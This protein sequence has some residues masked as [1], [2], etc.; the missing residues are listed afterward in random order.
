MVAPP[1]PCLESTTK[2]FSFVVSVVINHLSWSLMKIESIIIDQDSASCSYLKKCLLSRFPEITIQGE[3]SSI[4][5]ACKLIERVSPELVF[6]EVKIFDQI[7]NQ[8]T[9]AVFETVYL[10]DRS[11]DAI[12]AIWQD[13]CGFIL[14]PLKLSDIV[15]SVRSAIQKLS[16]RSSIAKIQSLGSSDSPLLPHTKLIGIPTMEGMEFIH[17]HE[18]VRCEGLQKC[19]RIVSSR[20]TN[21]ISSYN[22]GEFK[23]LLEEYGFFPCHKSHLINLMHVKRFTREGFVYL[24]DNAAVP[25]ARRKRPEF[26]HVLKHL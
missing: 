20:K 6:S 14:K 5:E 24:S 25:L 21:L 26:L 3:A 18:I 10:S 15:L 8:Q 2:S 11:E 17:V 1:D 16:S 4:C 12:M 19:T 22:I 7:R 23:K 13:A 9:L